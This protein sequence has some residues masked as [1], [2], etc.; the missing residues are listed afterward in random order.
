MR[1]CGASAH[2]PHTVANPAGG[3]TYL[4]TPICPHL[5]TSGSIASPCGVRLRNPLLRR[6]SLHLGHAAPRTRQSHHLQ[7]L[8]GFRRS[9]LNSC[10]LFDK[11]VRLKCGSDWTDPPVLSC[12]RV[13]GPISEPSLNFHRL[14]RATPYVPVARERASSPLSSHAQPF[15]A[16]HS[17]VLEFPFPDSLQPLSHQPWDH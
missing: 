14:P 10:G 3:L 7:W 11:R 13:V 8:R 1:A 4:P 9:A 16:F 5:A 12:P 2:S 17:L 6:A 15:A